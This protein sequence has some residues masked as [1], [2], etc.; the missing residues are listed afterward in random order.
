MAL[1]V[2]DTEVKDVFELISKTKEVDSEGHDCVIY[3]KNYGFCSQHSDKLQPVKQPK[4]SQSRASNK[5]TKPKKEKNTF[6]DAR[7]M[8]WIIQKESIEKKR[9]EYRYWMADSIDGKVG[10][11]GD[12]KRDVIK[13]IKNKFGEFGK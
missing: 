4:I 2:I 11:K 5:P 13:Q 1:Y 12:L 9:G 6:I 3:N 10:Y 7:G 8:K